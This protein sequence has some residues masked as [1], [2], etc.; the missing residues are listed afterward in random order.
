MKLW[1]TTIIAATSFAISGSATANQLELNNDLAY[2]LV[3][4]LTVEVG[5]RLAG[6]EADARAVAWAEQKFNQLGF[7][8]VWTEPFTMQYWER[9]NASLRVEAPFNQALVLTAL[10]G[11]IGTPFDG[12]SSQV[13][14]FDNLQQL[15]QADPANV[16]DKI[17]FINQALRKD[18]RGS[19]Y[20]QVVGARAQGAVEA[21]KLGA[22]A[23]IIRSVGTSN[24]RFAHTGIM[25]Y[26]E[27]V[28]R[29]PAA[30]I[31][32]PDAQQLSKML[33]I[34]PE[35][36]L[37]LNMK[38]NLPGEVTSHNVIAEI[39]GSKRPKEIV[40]ISA[41]IDSWDEGTGALDDG[42]GVGLVMATAALL[43]Q[44]K[45]ERTIRVV[46]FGN[47]EG[48]LI[49]ARAYAARHA[50]ELKN[51][52][53]ASESDFGAGRIWRFDTGFGE[54]ALAFGSDLQQQLKYL[55]IEA[56][57]NTASGGPDVS[58][59]KAMG[60]PVASL[61]Q[62]GT[63]YFDFHHTP[64]DTL[65]KIDPAALQQNLQAWLIMTRIIANSNVDLRK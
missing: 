35:T 5:P 21:A 46:L 54:Q 20:G 60:V 28:P 65:D 41:H 31:S 40:L 9:G 58:V 14:M 12:I 36:S 4:S 34:H 10:G 61:Q 51:H 3:E 30:A 29:I 49:G 8:K 23:I 15:Q 52:V 56:G 27:D 59:L 63:D 33:A 19:F 42:A 47:E 43:K 13:V 18:I 57:T 6:S 2:K 48:G 53:F 37:S 55:G 11:S 50:A 24:N 26:S 1:L 64:N 44:H 39:T 32:V 17:V 7:D 38:N 45:P 25:R 22:K 16:K 62:D